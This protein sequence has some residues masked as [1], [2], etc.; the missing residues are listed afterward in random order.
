MREHGWEKRVVNGEVR[1]VKTSLEGGTYKTTS[2]VTS[3]APLLTFVFVIAAFVAFVGSS[4]ELAGD[5]VRNDYGPFA[6]GCLIGAGV[7]AFLWWRDAM[8]NRRVLRE[9]EANTQR[10]EERR[11][12]RKDQWLREQEEE[13]ERAEERREREQREQHERRKEAANRLK[14]RRKHRE[15]DTY[16][17]QQQ[18]GI[19]E[20]EYRNAAEQRRQRRR[21][22]R[23]R[24]EEATHWAEHQGRL[25]EEERGRS[26]E[27]RER[28]RQERLKR[29]EEAANRAEQQ[30][31]AAEEEHRRRIE[32]L[33][34]RD[35]VRD[36]INHMSGPEFERFMA[37]LFRQKGY[38]VKQTPASGDQ[39]VDLILPDY[40]G[41]RVAVQLKRW[42][43][44]VGN[45]V[46]GATL[47]GRVHYGAEE[48]W[49]ITTSTFTR[50]ARELARSTG[51][52]LID[53]KE[54]AAWL[55]GLREEP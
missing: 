51:V 14:G 47:A 33:L 20:E 30:K 8:D 24:R 17:T 39:G 3:P 23:E 12:A 26:E 10:E 25:A 50:S 22:R 35:A 49:V 13:R 19:V 44:P 55:E 15:E 7:S 6:G 9:H 27:Q 1:K 29:S 41:R 36:E 11:Q 21:E 28:E 5:G 4:P 31:R 32:A 43:G 40:D 53:G 16:W 38:A 54:L 2:K 34:Q 18:E 45:A 42:S 52:R 46:V 37:D 48:G